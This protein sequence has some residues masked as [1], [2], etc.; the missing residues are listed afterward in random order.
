[1]ETCYHCSSKTATYQTWDKKYFCFSCAMKI[2]GLTVNDAVKPIKEEYTGDPMDTGNTTTK[3]IE[4]TRYD[5]KMLKEVLAAYKS[6]A[7]DKRFVDIEQPSGRYVIN[8]RMFPRMD[9]VEEMLEDL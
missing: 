4:L 6:L 5:V 9:W 8:G 7:I 1:M 3:E 2:W